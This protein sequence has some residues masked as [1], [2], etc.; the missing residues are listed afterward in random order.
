MRIL[1]LAVTACALAVPAL[2]LGEERVIHFGDSDNS[3]NVD[4]SNGNQ[5]TFSANSPSP[6]SSRDFLIASKHHDKATPL[7]LDSK[8]N[9]AIHIAAQTFAHDVYRVTGIKPDLYNDT[10]PTHVK[11]AIIVGSVESGL[12]GDLENGP[13]Y[14]GLHG[15]WESYDVQVVSGP[16]KNVDKALVVVGSDRRGTIYALYTMSEQMGVSPFHYWADVPVRPQSSIEFSSDR[17][18]S[19][20]EPTVKYRGLFINDEHPAMWEWAARKQNVKIG[21]PAFTTWVYEPWLEM[22]LRLKANYFWPAM[23]ASMFDV[24]G[25]EWTEDQP[26]PAIPGPNQVLANRMGI[27]MGTSHHEPMARNKPEWDRKGQGAWDW[28]N[29]EFMKQWWMDGAK[30]AKGMETLFTLG[31]RGDGD[32]PLTGASNALVENITATQQQILGEVYETD[33]MS[34]IPQMWCM[35]KEVAEYYVNGLQVPEDVTVLFADDNWGNLMSV[36]NPDKPHKAGG[37]IYYHVDYVG[38]P[39]AYKWIQTINLA[40]TWEQMSIAAAFNTTSIWILNV[41]TLKPLELP[42]E[43][44]MSLAWDINAW[45][46]N[47]VDRFLQHW[48]AREFGEEVSDE[49]ADIMSKYTMY[50]SRNKAEVMNTTTFSLTNYEEAERVL[51]E[52]EAITERAGKVYDGLPE[53]TRPAF[54]EL[55]Y[56]LCLAQTN[57]NKL[58]MA[59]GRNNIYAQQAR[60]AANVFGKE[61]MDLFFNDWN[62]TERFHALLDRKWDHMWDQSHI[63]WNSHLEPEKD[64]LPPISWVNPMVPARQGI[65]VTELEYGQTSYIRVTH[66]NSKGSWP[67][68]TVDNCPR[69]EHCGLPSLLPMDPYGAKSRWIDVG[70]AGPKDVRFKV[71]TED[72]IKVEPS[73]GKIMRDAS[74]DTRLRLSIDWSKAPDQGVGQFKLYGSDLSNVTINV[75]VNNY[76]KPG[77]GF[78]GFIEGDGYVVM[79]AAHYSRNTSVQE[80]AF[81]EVK[82]YGRTL[83]GLEMYPISTQNFTL[84]EGPSLEYDF[85]L[86]NS[87]ES[88]LNIQIGPSLNFLGLN[89][90]LAFGVQIDDEP[91]FLIRPI[92][93]EPLGFAIG[94]PGQTPVA[95]GAVPKDWIEIVKNEIRNVMFPF[96]F[97]EEGKHTLKIWGMTTGIIV[98]R[99][100]VDMG[101]ISERGYSYLG[102]PESQK[103]A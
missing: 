23:Y 33:D 39:K 59:A 70:A 3:D 93:T 53:E 19:H 17:K 91:P 1:T 51:A 5:V 65:P 94:R 79:E 37:G 83:S 30:R 86:H 45:P 29:A 16:L 90:T 7:L 50:A 36:I 88:E 62:I 68:N 58:Y 9:E 26:F 95:I 46:I 75:P 18:L 87:G 47:S 40:K 24:D 81:Q 2:G 12:I 74:T 14:D 67:G 55:V 57:L 44:F 61:A 28:T 72:W 100:W 13:A 27:V 10:L 22:M 52:W 21:E 103:H 76:A 25:L 89:K 92:P 69:G 11:H 49:V 32:M 48:A 73:H 41:G 101:G 84:G 102:P 15:K 96:E 42:V 64:S 34:T 6:A 60:T 77:S 66:E 20:G 38:T 35:Y 98:E 82:G 8:D 85:W 97:E 54:F 4:L 43:H 63:N 78:E 99:I 80:Y 31:M 56:M 71:E